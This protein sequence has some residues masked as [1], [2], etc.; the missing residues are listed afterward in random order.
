MRI[1]WSGRARVAVLSGTLA[2]GGLIG[3]LGFAAPAAAASAPIDVNEACRLTWNDPF[4]KIATSG[5]GPYSLFCYHIRYGIPQEF[6]YQGGVDLQ[7]WC[8]VRLP[9][10]RAVPGRYWWDWSCQR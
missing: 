3:G 7:K 1:T 6:W 5:V 10:S 4:S 2:L 9:G 8:N